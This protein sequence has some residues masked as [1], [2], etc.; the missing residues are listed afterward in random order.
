MQVLKKHNTNMD[1]K[2][3]KTELRNALNDVSWFY[4]KPTKK[5]DQWR[6]NSLP[7]TN[8]SF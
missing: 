3:S 4:Q 2:I 1:D 5:N 8:V 6:F 7:I